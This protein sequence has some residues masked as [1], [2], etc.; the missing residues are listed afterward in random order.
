METW[1]VVAVAMSKDYPGLVTK[2]ITVANPF[3][4]NPNRPLYIGGGKTELDGQSY[5]VSDPQFANRPRAPRYPFI[6]R[7]QDVAVYKAP[8]INLRS[9]HAKGRGFQA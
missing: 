8:T 6:G 7:I 4:P 3:V 2:Q 5:S 9:H 1:M